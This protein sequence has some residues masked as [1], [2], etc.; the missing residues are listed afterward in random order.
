[1]CSIPVFAAFFAGW[2]PAFADVNL[3]DGNF[4]LADVERA[5]AQGG[6]GA[7]IPVHMF[8][9]PDDVESLEALCRRR[10]ADLV[11]DGALSLGA[12]RNG[13][14]VGS[15]GRVSCVS[16]VRKILPLE[17]GGAVLTDEPA[18][19]RRADA[20]ARSLPP[21]GAVRPAETAAAMRA[22]HSLTGFV[23]AGGWERASLLHGWGE[24]FR[25][26]LLAS[27]AEGEWE[28]S[29]VPEEL[30]RLADLVQARR[31]R[32]EVYET[33]LA[34][35]LLE[36]PP[37]EGSS[38]FAYPLRLRGID[39]E[40]FLDFAAIQGYNFKRIA[41]PAIPRV[42]GDGGRFPQAE[43]LEREWVGLP[44]DERRPVSG[45]WEYAEDFMKAF[46]SYLSARPRRPSFDGRGRLS[47]RMGAGA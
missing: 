29:V 6:V 31:A 37:R 41:Y 47:L 23:A 17:M 42:F 3:V 34:H 1:M 27:T 44:L 14:P 9:R 2:E 7:V 11:E 30:A 32:A 46:I 19:A 21:G 10:G 36:A 25:R 35:D 22:F 16:F 26:L 20:F 28:G 15:F 8:G 18:L 39:A 12:E 43:I 33:V 13:R 45:F 5:L 24:E 38:L 4:D 40:D